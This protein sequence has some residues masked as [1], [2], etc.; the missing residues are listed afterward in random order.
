M[1]AGAVGAL[2]RSRVCDVSD[3]MLA[4]LQATQGQGMQWLM[5][6]INR[7]PEAV[8]AQ[9]DKV[10]YYVIYILVTFINYILF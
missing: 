2:P 1:L 3:A 5:E 6:C 8:A 10:Q 4:V 9:G 7:L